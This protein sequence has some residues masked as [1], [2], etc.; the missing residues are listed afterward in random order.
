M[1]P[2]RV[3]R[4]DGSVDGIFTAIY[5]AYESRYGH[6]DI[7]IAETDQNTNLELFTEYIDTLTDEEKAEKVASSIKTKISLDAYEVVIK[8]ALSKKKG[9]ADAIYRFLQLGF[10]T[11]RSVVNQLSHPYVLPVFE[12]E[13]T[14]NNEISHYLQFVRFSELKNTILLSRIRPENNII[15]LIAPHFEDRLTEENW[16]IYDEGRNLAAVHKSRYPWILVDGKEL[17]LSSLEQFSDLEI[18]M[19]IFWQT[20]V[21]T[22]AIKERINENLQKQMLPNRYREFM[23]EMPYKAK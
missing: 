2:K 10:A 15:T 22:I 4:C 14:V 8:S 21:D 20:F 6:A 17:N 9:R 23:R 12:M 16:M 3:Y 13:R 7:V 1:K 5:D 18:D 11:G 19:Q